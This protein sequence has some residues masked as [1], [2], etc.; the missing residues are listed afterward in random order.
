MQTLLLYILFFLSGTTALVYELVWVRQLVFVFGGTTYAI[1]TVLVAFMAGLGLG[2]YLAGRWCHRLKHPARIFGL[3][4]VGI[5]VYALLVP[6]LLSVADPLYQAVYP[7]THDM[8]WLLTALRFLIGGTIVLVP[9]TLMGAT[10]PVLVRHVTALGGKVGSSV[11]YL[12]GV[13]TFGAVLGVVLAG[14]LMLPLCGLTLTTWLAAS[15]DVSV[16]ILAFILLPKAAVPTTAARPEVEAAPTAA[17][18]MTP[19]IQSA[20]LIGYAV[21]GFTAM[22][23]QITWTRALIMSV[24]SSTYSFTCIL[25]AFILGLAVGALIIARFADRVRNPAYLV[26]V[27]E[28]LIG[29]VAVLIVPIHGQIPLVVRDIVRAYYN[30]YS[31]LVGLQ[32]LLVIAVTI[33][34]TLLMGAIFPLVI[35][36]L[37]AG[38]AEAGAVTGWAYAV[39]TI[40]TITGSALAGFILIRSEVL[41]VQNSIVFASVLNGVVGLVL[42]LMSQRPA[43]QPLI[44]RAAI[45]VFGLL[46]IPLVAMTTGKWDQQLMTTAPFLNR[47]VRDDPNREILY[48]AEGVDLTVGVETVTNVTDW[49]ELTVNGKPDA[50]T[51]PEDM[52]SFMLLGHIP[53][54]FSPGANSA[55]VIGLGSGLTM[56]SLACYPGYEVMD[57]IEISDEVITAAKLF[58][59]YTNNVLSEEPRLNMIRAD[60]RNHLLLTEQNYDL[61]LSQPS[62]PWMAGVANL[63]TYEFFQLGRQRLNEEGIFAV[64]LQSYSTSLHD[65]RMVTH[66]LLDVFPHVTL[67]EL[68]SG[69]YLLLATLSPL[70]ISLDDIIK[71][72]KVPEVRAD[73][74]RIAIADPAQILGRFIADEGVLGEWSAGTPRHTDDNALLEF[75]APRYLYVGEGR[76]ISAALHALQQSVFSQVVTDTP[77]IAMRQRVQGVISGRRAF[78]N[79]L[80]ALDR[81]EL[82]PSLQFMLNGAEADSRSMGLFR[83]LVRAT[84]EVARDFP[85]LAAQPAV[86]DLLGK[87][88]ALPALLHAPPYGAS[89]SELADNLRTMATQARNAYRF[90]DAVRYLEEALV[91][92]PGDAGTIR[93]L[94]FMLLE[95]GRP[96]EAVPLL[97][98]LLETNPGDGRVIHLRAVAA[99]MLDDTEKALTL[100]EAAVQADLLP[101]KVLREDPQFKPL[102]DN[103][104]FKALLE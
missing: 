1:T 69:D 2:S 73:L 22:V 8:P 84:H 85:E 98:G 18:H 52:T 95:A 83:L 99:V 75:S 79:A 7:S 58:D 32:F 92:E 24:G 46:L 90:N 100:L 6:L 19:A 15:V 87:L 68:H 9:A 21:S 35:R 43:G 4:E 27:L 39:N 91:F 13:N 23:Y 94:S 51:S 63:F 102:H 37:A 11:G 29:L 48:Y 60:G 14:F 5:G 74:Y 10:L 96:A 16:G 71:R 103:P 50:S 86:A 31:T 82:I 104:R 3:L 64:W 30:D 17:V 33:V 55:C 67:W 93:V 81:G 70:Q 54:M 44:R 97:D 38:G 28:L 42:V 36:A 76:Q 80:I 88:N 89:V 12:Y 72:F 101:T 45:P 20:L 25:A 41:G 77:S 62:N 26:G 78:L 47:A 65:F 61:I 53:A 66:T 49:L 56:S 40:G 59:P 57:C 34:P